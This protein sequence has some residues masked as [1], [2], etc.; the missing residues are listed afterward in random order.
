MFS[1]SPQIHKIIDQAADRLP[2]ALLTLVIGLVV[3]E[4]LIWLS[5]PLLRL[6]RLKPGLR[7]VLR[8]IIRSFLWIILFISVIQALGLNNVF[9][10]FTGST[11]ILALLLSTGVAP[12]ITDLLAGLFLAS[13]KEF[14]PGARVKAGDKETEGVIEGIDVRK[15]RIRDKNGKLHVL[16][17]SIVE[18]NEWVILKERPKRSTKRPHRVTVKK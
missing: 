17:N 7:K 5:S 13:D 1:L 3:V 14:Q 12:M 4:L 11:L 2:D 6:A 9:V 15:I 18:K 16:P 8:S 10:A